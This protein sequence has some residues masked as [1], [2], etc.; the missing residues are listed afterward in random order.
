MKTGQF[1]K[2]QYQN[3]IARIERELK[4]SATEILREQEIIDLQKLIKVHDHIQEGHLIVHLNC[5]GSIEICFSSRNGDWSHLWT[6]RCPENFSTEVLESQHIAKLKSFH[7]KIAAAKLREL[8][9][10]A[11]LTSEITVAK[12]WWKFW[13]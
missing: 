5:S 10:K 3:E 4:A 11:M 7:P 12:P 9:K 13:K 1:I 8:A 2:T 6:S